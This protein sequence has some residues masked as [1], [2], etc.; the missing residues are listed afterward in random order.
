M[1]YVVVWLD[2]Y[3]SGCMNFITKKKWVKKMIIKLILVLS[4]LCYR[5]TNLMLF[6]I[7]EQCFCFCFRASQLMYRDT[8]KNFTAKQ[9]LGLVF[10]F[11]LALHS[12]Y[13]TDRNT[14]YFQKA[15]FA[16]LLLVITEIHSIIL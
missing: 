10:S 12:E 2:I 14:K 11:I 7:I 13:Y 8:N 5:E 3:W 9:C 6:N 1:C 15:M 4:S 16:A